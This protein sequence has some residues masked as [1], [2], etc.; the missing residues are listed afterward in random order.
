MANTVSKKY[1]KEEFLEF[2][3]NYNINE[4]IIN[5]FIELPKFIKQKDSVFELDINVTYYST[6]NTYYEF[7]INY[8]SQ[9]LIEYLF[10]WKV[11]KNV[12]HSINNIQ[13]NLINNRLI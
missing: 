11:F 1:S 2:L 4:N 12:E 13:C 5:K 6:K 9:E 10:N 7:E 3:K 8:Y